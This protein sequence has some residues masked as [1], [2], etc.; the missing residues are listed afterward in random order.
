MF[1]AGQAKTY[2]F[3]AGV[4][5]NAKRERSFGFLFVI[6]HPDAGVKT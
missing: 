4:A 2:L 6:Q 3:Q 1:R 5:L